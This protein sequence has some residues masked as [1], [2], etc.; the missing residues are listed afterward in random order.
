[1][2]DFKHVE[3]YRENNRIEAKRALGGL[4]Y[5]VWETYS[6]FANTM[7]GVILLGVEEGRD[8]SFHAV[9]LP[10]PQKLIDKF[11][12]QLND[13]RRVNVNIL[14]KDDVR[15]ERVEGKRI[16]VIEVPRAHR[17]DKPVYI[18]NDMLHGTYRRGGE[19][20]Y[21]C[22]SE[23]IAAMRRD[24]AERSQD[25]R[26]LEEVSLSDLC[27]ET[28]AR[29]RAEMKVLRPGHALERCSSNE[30][31]IQLNAAGV[32]GDGVLHPSAAGLLMFGKYEAIC[33]TFP[34]YQVA[35][36]K[37]HNG[38]APP[39]DTATPHNLYS[40]FHCVM[41]D[42]RLSFSRSVTAQE[43]IEEALTNCL[44]NA[45]Y[46]ER[47]GVLVE[48]HADMLCFSN[49]GAFR[50]DPVKARAGGI[51][52]AR[53]KAL[54][55]MFLLI[56]VGAGVGG[57]IPRMFAAWR[58][59]AHPTPF[60]GEYFDPERTTLTLPLTKKST[61]VSERSAQKRAMPK[62]AAK[63]MLA[64]HL[65]AVIFARA[66]QIATAMGMPCSRVR[67][68]LAEMRREGIVISEGQGKHTVWKLR[69]KAGN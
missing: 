38:D 3:K 28:I 1:M 25:M 52:D 23:E 5:S 24:A 4:P 47:G 50:V 66:A 22:T 7:G 35:L 20:D 57:G 37:E 12:R 29:Y 53:N 14:T 26:L 8:K 65:T 61:Y 43:A 34:A 31:L 40:F 64:E 63:Q 55:R 56:G 2:I 41:A 13:T 33:R 36:K 18:E 45:D 15:I 48:M 46:R 54:S 16:V 51:S 9:D 59:G 69:E 17:A 21:R 62:A 10:D 49:P 42:M 67:R 6:S 60:F 19:G 11:W 58:R 32:G 68:Y 30:F 44:V 39:V 27:E